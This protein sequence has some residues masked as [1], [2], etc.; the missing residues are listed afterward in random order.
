MYFLEDEDSARL[1]FILFLSVFHQVF[2]YRN[3]NYGHHLRGSSVLIYYLARKNKWYETGGFI[4]L[5]ISI[6]T[7]V[8][9]YI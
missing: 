8:G 9:P 1:S 4:Q 3:K 2:P 6:F 5:V 7:K